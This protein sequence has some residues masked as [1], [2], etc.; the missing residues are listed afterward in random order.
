MTR[1]ERAEIMSLIAPVLIAIAVVLPL[2]VGIV[3]FLWFL[4]EGKGR[5]DV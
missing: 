1:R 2:C 3:V 4:G 5:E